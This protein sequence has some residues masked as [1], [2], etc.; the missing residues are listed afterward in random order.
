VFL[1]AAASATAQTR[2][3]QAQQLPKETVLAF[4]SRLKAL[5]NRAYPA[6]QNE[7]ALVRKFISSL[8]GG[9]SVKGEIMR[10]KPRT[11][12]AALEAA[13]EEVSIVDELKNT[14]AGHAIGGARGDDEAMDISALSE[15]EA[16]CFRCKKK[17]HFKRNCPDVPKTSGGGRAT[18]GTV[19]RNTGARPKEG[20]K[21]EKP[22]W[23][24]FRKQVEGMRKALAALE[25][26]ND[27]DDED[28]EEPEG[29]QEDDTGD[30][31]E[32]KDF[33]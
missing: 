23:K 30:E 1:P 7:M 4:H 3:D 17:G 6:N 11:Y 22:R 18:T 8:R 26:G 2:Y 10:A 15:S 14:Q 25:E 19:T 13:M 29:D 32:G 12:Q 5:Y 16:Y 27:D 33:P 9:N 28:E 31:S 20:N 21:E 24:N